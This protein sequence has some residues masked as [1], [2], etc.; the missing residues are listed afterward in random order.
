MMAVIYVMRTAELREISAQQS[1]K[2]GHLVTDTGGSQR[3]PHHGRSGRNNRLAGIVFQKL[4]RIERRHAHAAEENRLRFG[5][6][7]LP[8]DGIG[9]LAIFLVDIPDM[10][11]MAGADD[12]DAACLDMLLADFVVKVGCDR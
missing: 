2:A 3:V 11:Q 4:Q 12:V 1:P 8:G 10:A 9:P 6:I 5:T 7:D